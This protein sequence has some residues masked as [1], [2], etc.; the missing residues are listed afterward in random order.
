MRQPW[1]L[2]FCK[3]WWSSSI[4][5]AEDACG[6]TL[7]WYPW[8]SRTCLAE[9][10]FGTEIRSEENFLWSSRSKCQQKSWTILKYHSN[11][12]WLL[13]AWCESK[14]GRRPEWKHEHSIKSSLSFSFSLAEGALRSVLETLV[15]V[16]GPPSLFW[17]R[18]TL[19]WPTA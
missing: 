10:N 7:D 17:P 1:I 5:G 11:T 3:L 8:F 19:G 4:I 14:E 13:V 9:L 12:T 18:S 6:K 15:R 2:E 16:L